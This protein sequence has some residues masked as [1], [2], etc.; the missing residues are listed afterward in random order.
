MIRSIPV[1]CKYLCWCWCYFDRW[2]DMDLMRNELRKIIYWQIWNSNLRWWR[3]VTRHWR[4][5]V[6]F[7]AW[8]R[9]SS[10]WHLWRHLLIAIGRWL[11]SIL[12]RRRW[13]CVVSPVIAT[14][15]VWTR[16]WWIS[17]HSK[18]NKS[19]VLFISVKIMLQCN[20]FHKFERYF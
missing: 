17:I 11:A 3:R 16:P 6:F 15:P 14:I 2:V 5:N 8:W 12:W 19:D 10:V 7:S 18:F 20:C 13:R 4:W 1:W 9:Q